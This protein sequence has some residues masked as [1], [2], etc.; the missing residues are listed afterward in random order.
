MAEEIYFLSELYKEDDP[1]KKRQ[2][3]GGLNVLCKYCGN[4]E[5]TMEYRCVP[6]CAPCGGHRRAC[7]FVA[8]S[9]YGLQKDEDKRKKTTT[10]QV[11]YNG[12]TGDLVKLQQKEAVIT[13]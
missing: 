7:E 9:F 4:F 5:A 11:T 8:D 1:Q 13:T 3:R 2:N 12:F 6:C 10:M